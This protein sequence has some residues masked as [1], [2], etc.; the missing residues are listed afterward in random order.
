LLHVPTNEEVK[1]EIESSRSKLSQSLYAETGH[2]IG[3]SPVEIFCPGEAI[4]AP[5]GAT[6]KPVQGNGLGSDV[7]ID[8]IVRAYIDGKRPEDIQAECPIIRLSRIYRIIALYLDQHETAELADR[9]SPP[10]AA[11]DDQD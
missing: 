2:S 4:P 6:G 8:F 5:V 7:P 11:D 3:H 9:R 10:N 1:G